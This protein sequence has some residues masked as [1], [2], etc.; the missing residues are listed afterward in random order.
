MWIIYAFSEHVMLVP[1][2]TQMMDQ[3]AGSDS[4]DIPT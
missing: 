4:S 1:V 2:C 3:A